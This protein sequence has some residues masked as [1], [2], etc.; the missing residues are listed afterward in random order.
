[1]SVQSF[2]EEDIEAFKA[3]GDDSEL[4]E[5]CEKARTRRMEYEKKHPFTPIEYLKW[6][7]AMHR[8]SQEKLP[9]R[10]MTEFAVSI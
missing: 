4:R 3:M 6:L 5:A 9:P 2:S 10:K 8:I 7:N 1:M